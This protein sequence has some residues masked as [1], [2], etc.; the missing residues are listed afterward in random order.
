MCT[1]DNHLVLISGIITIF[2]NATFHIGNEV[3][4]LEVEK[5]I[6]KLEGK[7]R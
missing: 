6:H 7:N 5:S 3:L 2:Y 1:C 4:D